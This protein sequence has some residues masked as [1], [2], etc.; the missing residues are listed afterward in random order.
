MSYSSAYSLNFAPKTSSTTNPFVLPLLNPC[1]KAGTD[2]ISTVNLVSGVNTA[3]GTQNVTTGIYA[4]KFYGYI[5]STADDINVT[6][7]VASIAPSDVNTV[8][9]SIISCPVGGF[10]MIQNQRYD[11]T[12]TYVF[13]VIAGSPSNISFQVDVTYTSASGGVVAFSGQAGYVKL[14]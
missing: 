10:E 6:N 3:V 1:N 7:A 4:I 9:S 2:T 12:M 11:F 13:M 14:P 5:S 8:A